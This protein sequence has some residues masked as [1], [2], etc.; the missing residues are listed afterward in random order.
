MLIFCW[1]TLHRNIVTVCLFDGTHIFFH[2]FQVI[3]GSFLPN[4]V[5]QHQRRMNL[6]PQPSPAS[7]Q[8]AAPM[9]RPR[10]LTAAMP[11]SQ[12]S[13][14]NGFHAP[15]PPSQP[16]RASADHGRTGMN[17]NTAAGFTMVGWPPNSQ[18]V[19]Y[20]SS[21]DINVSLTPHE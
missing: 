20:G 11:I 4:S 12:A 16:A 14:G 3:V 15:R 17:L 5:K 2:C 6:Q 13:P 8:P 18:S 1:F 19:A 10:V 21:P 9:P 7:A